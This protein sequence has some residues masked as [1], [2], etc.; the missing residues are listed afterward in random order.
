MVEKI[1]FQCMI[2]CERFSS[3]SVSM[4]RSPTPVTPMEGS[5]RVKISG[6]RYLVSMLAFFMKKIM[7]TLL[8]FQKEQDSRAWL[9][10]IIL[11]E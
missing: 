6:F 10:G 8:V 2:R 4:K 11:P 7:L 1:L 9:K 3:V 5:S